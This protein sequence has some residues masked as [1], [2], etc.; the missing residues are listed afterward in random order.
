[1]PIAEALRALLDAAHAELA[2]DQPA[3]AERRAKAVSAIIRAEQDVAAFVAAAAAQAP[4]EDAESIRAELRS[5]F[6][7]LVEAEHAGAP[8][9]V[10]ERLAAGTP[11]G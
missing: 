8:A 5:R 1:M 3:E 11:E 7:R 4:E 2:G 10:L 9:E 6:R